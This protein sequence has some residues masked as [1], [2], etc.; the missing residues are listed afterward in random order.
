MKVK[1]KNMSDKYNDFF[2]SKHEPYSEKS[3][4]YDNVRK[5]LKEYEG[6]KL[7]LGPQSICNDKTL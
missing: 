3:L 4:I 2:N 6:K 5:I 7:F 1:D